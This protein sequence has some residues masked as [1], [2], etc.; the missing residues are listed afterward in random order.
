[1]QPYDS[2]STV[3][4]RK[5]RIT[6]R[7]LEHDRSQ[8]NETKTIERNVEAIIRHLRYNPGTYDS[9]IALLKLDQR[10]G[11]HSLCEERLQS[12]VQVVGS[13]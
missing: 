12:V 8:A 1:M 5:E 6:V 7:F 2:S 13:I 11:E 3:R 4:F 9:D 10:V